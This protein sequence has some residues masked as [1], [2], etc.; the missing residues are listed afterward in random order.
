MELGERNS[1]KND[2]RKEIYLIFPDTV[3]FPA[4]LWSKASSIHCRDL[5]MVQLILDI[6]DDKKKKKA[7]DV[8][9]IFENLI[10]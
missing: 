2:S 9:V 7:Q 8:V 4:L 1:G 5:F 3:L 10:V 6:T